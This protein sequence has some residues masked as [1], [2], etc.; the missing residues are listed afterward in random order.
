MSDVVWG[1]AKAAD[2]ARW[3][4]KCDSREEAIEEGRRELGIEPGG[5]FWI[6]TGTMATAAEF[7]P[8]AEDILQMAG[9]HAQDE[10]GEIAED[11]P[12]ISNEEGEELDK[13]LEA[14]I[15]KHSPC[16]FW[17]VT[18]EPEQVTLP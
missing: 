3:K 6:C 9:E 18:G 14:W 8:S 2:A 5:S 1:Y 16:S 11:W 12:D 10:C 4:G 17:H 7:M 15:E 13:F